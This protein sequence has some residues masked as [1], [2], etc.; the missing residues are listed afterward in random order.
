MKFEEIKELLYKNY[1]IDALQIEKVKNTYKIKTYNNIYCL[2]VI[3]YEF[4]HF[5][6][7]ISAIK[8]L[9][10][11]NFSYL[12][13]IINTVDNKDFIKINSNFA[14]LTPW[15]NCRECDYDNP[16][17]LKN[18]AT[19][20]GELHKCSEGFNLDKNMKPRIGWFKWIEIFETRGKEILDFKHRI[21]Q[22]A[23]KSEFDLIYLNILDKEIK[24][25]ENSI[26]HLKESNYYEKMKLEVMKKGFCHHD[27]AHHNVLIDNFQQFYIIDFDYCILDSKLHDLS[28]ICV[29]S[30]KEGKWDINKFILILNGYFKSNFI[31]NK[32][33]KLMASFMEFPQ[34]YWQL[35]IQYYW[36]Q[37]P[38]KEEFFVKKLTKYIEDIE[39]RQEFVNNLR[40]FNLR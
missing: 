28:S 33:I 35:G 32:D 29:R 16:V 34:A 36:E 3:K 26:I 4:A 17:D 19:K 15:I 38:W 14:Y 10:R 31:E 40:S 11:R 20:L 9:Q 13:K 6:F 39:E 24:R 5:Y 37:Q 1:S 18:A 2:K 22:K 27:Y 25:V 23:Y 8:Y 7:I 30:M 12:P 21:F